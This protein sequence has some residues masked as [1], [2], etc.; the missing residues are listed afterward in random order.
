MKAD[1]GFLEYSF[2]PDV[3]PYELVFGKLG[4]L[5]FVNRSRHTS[6]YIT[7][8]TQNNAILLIRETYNIDQPSLTG[9]GFLASLH[10]IQQFGCNPDP[11]TDL[12]VKMNDAGLRTLFIDTNRFTLDASSLMNYETVD[13]GN[14]TNPGIKLITGVKYN[15]C[16]PRMMD[17]YQS[18]GFKFTRSTDTYNTLVSAN[19]RFTILCSKTQTDG[20]IKTVITDTDDVFKTTSSL[21]VAGVELKTFDVSSQELNFGNLNH[22]IVG[23]NC[24]AFGN[25]ES[26]T[27]ENFIPEAA[28][29]LD[30]IFRTR[31]QYL[32][33]TGNTLDTHYEVLQQV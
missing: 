16:N 29:D 8:W 30:V 26:Y 12:W 22:K 3:T 10:D 21:T 18:M 19:N 27:I 28:P 4:Q 6:G 24:L 15:S 13:N 2:N 25:K 33:I 20:K 1:F 9:L 5:G 31:K 23:Y 32:H 17:F 14:Y 7:V 11:E